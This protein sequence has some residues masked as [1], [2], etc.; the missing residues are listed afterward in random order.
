MF[1]MKQMPS[2]QAAFLGVF[3]CSFLPD[4][5]GLGWE[6]LALGCEL[7]KAAHEDFSSPAVRNGSASLHLSLFCYRT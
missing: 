6:E 3:F 4:F 1:H 7:K 5:L 2:P